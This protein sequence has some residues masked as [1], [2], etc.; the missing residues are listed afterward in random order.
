LWLVVVLA[1]HLMVLAEVLVALEQVQ[2]WLLYLALRIQLPWALVAQ[3]LVVQLVVL[4]L[5]LQLAHLL[6]L[7]QLAAAGVQALM[8]VLLLRLA[9]LVVAVLLVRQQVLVT[10]P[11]LLQAKVMLE[12]FQMLLRL[13]AGAVQVVLGKIK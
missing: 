13:L 3:G 4:E 6:L 5:I 10:P 8:E 11:Q 1:V 7:R 12:E 9:V 2:D